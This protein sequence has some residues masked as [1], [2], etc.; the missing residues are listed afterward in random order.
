MLIK[1]Q[2]I[3]VFISGTGSNAKN[4]VNYFSF[5]PR[6]QIKLILSSKTNHDME[7]LCLSR[8]IN[9]LQAYNTQVV[10][11]EFLVRNCKENNIDWIVLAGFLKKIPN[12]LI[13]AYTNRI[14]NIHPSLLPKYGGKG[15][16]GDYVHQ[17]VLAA[18]EKKSGITIHLVN[19][20]YDKGKILAQFSVQLDKNE[21]LDSLRSKIRLL[22]HEHLP[23]VIE[24]SIIS[25]KMS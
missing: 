12:E 18:D 4:L 16:Y 11:S 17:A 20:E 9:F 3:A 21:N 15:M 8:K 19:E 7:E 1:K 6:I 23:Q 24:Q 2:N 14:F 25:N 5:N 10:D 13:Q 22:E